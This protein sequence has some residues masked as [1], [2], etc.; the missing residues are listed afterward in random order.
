MYAWL[1][2]I[3]DEEKRPTGF[4]NR[5][6]FMEYRN[7]FCHQRENKNTHM[8]WPN[9]FTNLE[10]QNP[11]MGRFYVVQKRGWT[12]FVALKL[13]TSLSGQRGKWDIC[14]RIFRISEDS[15]PSQSVVSK[16]ENQAVGFFS[17]WEMSP[18][19]DIMM[20]DLCFGIFL[21]QF[22]VFPSSSHANILSEEFYTQHDELIKKSLD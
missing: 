20:A 6:S 1:L 13:W 18:T 8:A 16:R 22:T 17:G 19:I 3:I 14:R 7:I 9:I 21:G 12:D 5:I 15:S 2:N 4:G 11:R 10:P